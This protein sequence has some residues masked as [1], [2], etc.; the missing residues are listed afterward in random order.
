V[1][2]NTGHENYFLG[3]VDFTP[4]K[5]DTIFARF[6]TD[7]AELTEPFGGSNIPLW[8][9]TN[10]TDNRYATV[11][12]RRIVS[13]SVINQARLG[14][15][16]TDEKADDTGA[17]PELQFFPGRSNGSVAP[18]GGITSIGANQLNPF[19]L[20]QNKYTI[21]DDLFWNAGAHSLRFGG[22][23]QKINSDTFAPFQWGGAWAF[24]GLQGFL[25]NQPGTL[26]SALVG[27]ENAFRKFREW[28][29]VAY[30]HDEWHAADTLTLNLGLRYAPTTNATVDP[31]SQIVDVP[32]GTFT[33]VTTV[34]ATNPS[35]KNWDPRLGFAWD[36]FADHK[37]SVRGGFGVFHDVIATRVYSSAYYI[38]PPYQ[39]ATEVNP[40]FPT[41]FVTPRTAP[42]V[43]QGIDFHTDT[44]P[45]QMS[46]NV[47]VQREIAA[48]TVITIGYVGSQGRNF[49]KQIDLNPA[50]PSQVNGVTVYGTFAP[51]STTVIPNPRLNP[52]YNGLNFGQ[53]IANSTYNSL[54][55]SANRR[56]YNNL[57]S[58]LS[59]TL[60]K[61]D[62]ISSGNFGGEGGTTA[63]NPYDPEYD[64][65]P[66]NFDRR[67]T[68]RGSAVYALPFT[69]NAFVEG[70]QLSGIVSLSSGTPFTP[71]TPNVSGLGGGRPNLVA[72]KT[73]DD[74]MKDD[75]DINRYFDPSV[76]ALPA[77]GTLGTVGRN[78]L[79]GPG[80]ATVDLSL[81]KSVSLGGVRS[82]QFRAEGF[83]VL[84]H[85]N[86][87]TPNAGVFVLTPGGQ[88]AISATA[89]R[90]TT[91][92]GDAR[93][94]QFAIKYL[95]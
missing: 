75:L 5:N 11:E 86:F 55:I 58:Q 21:A 73:I 93:R 31:G 8:P 68:F 13:T 25:L 70:W 6:V 81:S 14:Y 90:I 33:P 22:E 37:T 9:A 87:G 41:P 77:P 62:D 39:L 74:A 3:R 23:A 59:Y 78:S 91:V 32:F 43:S 88:G 19:D 47:N 36:P 35:L 46:Y 92:A 10:N 82:L 29:F 85:T 83:N 28:D 27:Q 72:G 71:T 69:G 80:F 84:N 24:N 38:N 17:V 63:T 89:G 60:S 45:Y 66:C 16:R 26:N 50:T 51:N 76:F 67:H 64:R 7:V 44:T 49:F 2:N 4:T 18:G 40:V 61:C 30:L 42:Q 95:F 65:G 34:F 20:L 57:Q 56:F 79:R 15:V 12:H 1:E 54:Q 53:T 48:A 52:A 94:M